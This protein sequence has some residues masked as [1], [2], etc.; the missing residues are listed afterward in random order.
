MR[1]REVEEEVRPA[2]CPLFN[3]LGVGGGD[4]LPCTEILGMETDKTADTPP[5]QAHH[6]YHDCVYGIVLR[7]VRLEHLPAVVR[8]SL[9]R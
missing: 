8:T 2:C 3:R 5:P 1:E 6:V 4:Q 7:V 9:A